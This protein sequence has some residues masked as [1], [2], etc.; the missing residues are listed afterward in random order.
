MNLGMDEFSTPT[1]GCQVA[2]L[3]FVFALQSNRQ[4]VFC[5]LSSCFCFLGSFFKVEYVFLF[6]VFLDIFVCVFTA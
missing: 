1:D 6:H 4:Q 2:C 3:S 5:F